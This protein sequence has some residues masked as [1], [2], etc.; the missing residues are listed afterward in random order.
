LVVDDEASIRFALGSYLRDR[1]HDVDVVASRV[2]AQASFHVTCHDLVITDQ[3]LARDTEGG[4][5]LVRWAKN[6]APHTSMVLMTAFRTPAIV[7]EAGGLGCQVLA[8][9]FS[10]D[11]IADL[12]A[13]FEGESQP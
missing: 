8:K 13:G 5:D 11:V 12:L 1:G 2:E 4:L 6:R 10:L 7:A 9:P 3:R